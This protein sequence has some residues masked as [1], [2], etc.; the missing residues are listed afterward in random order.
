MNLY[1]FPFYSTKEQQSRHVSGCLAFEDPVLYAANN[2]FLPFA[3]KKPADGKL[4]DCI[5]IYTSDD[6]FYGRILGNQISYKYYTAGGFDYMMYFGGA[7][8][9]VLP[10]GD[11]YLEIQG[12]YSE[13]F[14]VLNSMKGL[15]KLEWKNKGDIGGVL[16]QA[17]F[18]QR[19][20]LDTV[21]SEPA[22]K[23]EDEGADNEANEFIA[24]IRTVKKTLKVQTDLLPPFMMDALASLKLHDTVSF[25][26]HQAKEISFKADWPEEASG[27][28]GTAEIDFL[29]SDPISMK[30]CEEAVVLSETATAGYAPQTWLC[31]DDSPAAQWQ[32]TGASRC[33]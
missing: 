22:Y 26:Q 30:L 9:Q 6:Q 16:Y 15:V 8:Q 20:W 17:G 28:L 13:V 27:C 33:L 7:L 25:D 32:E 29:S 12:Y 1:A 21:I 3:I 31:G 4:I 11:Y 19:L 24:T 18:V 14:R 5:N 23:Y 10:C 2:R